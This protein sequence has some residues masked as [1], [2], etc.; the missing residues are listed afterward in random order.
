MRLPDYESDLWQVGAQEPYHRNRSI[1]LIMMPWVNKR[2]LER[3]ERDLLHALQR[4]ERAEAALADERRR[5]D[6][7]IASER[8]SKDF[9][10]LQLASRVVT[11]HGGYGL[12]AEPK[13]IEPELHPKGYI[14]EP[15]DIDYAR[16]EGYIEFYRRDGRSEEEAQA[17]WDSEMRGEQV[18][19]PFEQEH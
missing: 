6:D 16:L 12:E 9:L 13:T 19:Y 2:S 3:L 1:S 5:A 14:R 11:K 4:A 10:T 17:L 8:Q 18:V 15:S 7:L